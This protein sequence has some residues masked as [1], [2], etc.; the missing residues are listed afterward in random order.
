M[1]QETK[2]MQRRTVQDVMTK[3]VVTI[4]EETPF[5]EIAD[6]MAEHRISAVPVL[7]VM[8]RVTCIVTEADL[9]R[10]QE[11]KDDD[12]DHRPL[13]SRALRSRALRSRAPRSRAPRSRAPRHAEAE[14]KAAAVDARGLMSTPAVSVTPHTSIAQAA[15][16][17]NA[18]GFRAMPVIDGDGR[19]AGIVARRDLLRVFQ[20]SDA[21]IRDEVIQDVLIHKLWQD[22]A[23]LHVR[24][25]EGVVHLT[26]RVEQKSLIPIVVRLT[27]ATEG[28]VDVVH[29]LGYGHDDTRHTTYPRA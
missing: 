8:G 26:G 9:L 27:A 19:L 15:R 16:L 29:T 28:V 1:P 6:A 24:V 14:A 7:D 5:A 17:L 12:A 3:R 4:T 10:K 22:P 25:Q 18:H 2:I 23:E 21:D 20:R 11:Y 13:R